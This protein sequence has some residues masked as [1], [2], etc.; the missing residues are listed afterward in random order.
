[1]G[2]VGPAA[3]TPAPGPMDDF[4]QP[5]RAP[6]PMTMLDLSLPRQSAPNP[7]SVVRE[8]GSTVF[9]SGFELEDL[10]SIVTSEENDWTTSPQDFFKAAPIN[11]ERYTSSDRRSVLIGRIALRLRTGE[12]YRCRQTW[13][14]RGKTAFM[15]CLR[16]CEPE[17]GL[18]GIDFNKWMKFGGTTDI[19]AGKCIVGTIV[20]SCL[21]SRPDF[22][23][24]TVPRDEKH[25]AHCQFLRDL[26]TPEIEMLSNRF[27]DLEQAL[28]KWI[29]DR[30]SGLRKQKKKAPQYDKLQDFSVNLRSPQQSLYPGSGCG[31]C[32]AELGHFPDCTLHSIGQNYPNPASTF[33]ASDFRSP[34]DAIGIDSQCGNPQ[35]GHPAVA[36]QTLTQASTH[37]CQSFSSW[38]FKGSRTV[39]AEHSFVNSTRMFL[40]RRTISSEGSPIKPR[41]RTSLVNTRCAT[42][43]PFADNEFIF[44]LNGHGGPG[45]FS[46]PH[47]PSP[48]EALL[49][50]ENLFH[51]IKAYFENSCRHVNFDV[52]GNLLAPNGAEL[53]NAL[54][55]DFDS[56]CFTAAMLMGKGLSA[57]SRRAL[58]KAC[59]LVK[60][61]LRAE[62]PRTLA[63]F[64]E[65]F[66]HLIQ[67]G[68]P[69]VTS[70]LCNYI[71][72]MSATVIRRGHPCGKIYE[73]L[74]DLDSNSLEQALAQVWKCTTDIFDSELGECNRLAVSARL[75]YIKRVVPNHHEEERLLRDLLARF[76][77]IPRLPTPRV[78]LNLAHNFNKQGRH[79]EA[80][81]M[82]MEVL[83]LL[84]GYEMY[85]SRHVERI[86]SL[87]IVSRSQFDQGK[88]TEAEQTMQEVIQMIV[89]RWGMQHAWVPEFMN[90]LEGW[91]R[92][93]GRE[94][95]ADKL[96]GEI[97][98]L[99]GKD[100]TDV[101][102]NMVQD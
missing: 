19:I 63:C 52:H 14:Q 53:D 68:L 51:T 13:G 18:S 47:S 33:R 57:E 101:E 46:N 16:K 90:V 93:W 38:T 60:Q 35:S 42:A 17:H 61:I 77:G 64:L 48:P 24:R 54:C 56:Y 9:Q 62:H 29:R 59:A 79:D 84:Q 99:I 22:L 26:C 86:E 20:A 67:T 92:D 88:T 75:D 7:P 76:G 85:N 82:A 81:A 10:M 66:I 83:L 15:E 73:L 44:R 8:L 2:C 71:K 96:R 45:F 55:N 37:P 50:S 91:L 74:G 28:V 43:A 6:C 27:A 39:S 89:D 100:E 78:M 94:E 4:Q 23:Y 31:L 5:Y 11:V 1:M 3:T 72:R 58:S 80:E 70:Y 102:L 98:E 25:I 97:T 36:S 69:M 40:Q 65:V 12:L 41:T 32:P 34:G 49:V 87:K 95:D 30:Y 21:S